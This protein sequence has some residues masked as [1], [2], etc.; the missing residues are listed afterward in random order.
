MTAESYEVPPVTKNTRRLIVELGE[1]SQADL[2]CLVLSEGTNKT[3][4]VNR[5]IQLF[6][7]IREVEERGGSVELDDPQRGKARLKILS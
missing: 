4:V 2:E 3:T 5:A 1:K 6:K 7:L